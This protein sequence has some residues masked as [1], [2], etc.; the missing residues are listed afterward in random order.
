M[1]YRANQEFRRQVL[2]V[3]NDE[4][5]LAF[6]TQALELAGYEALGAFNR[7]QAE[8]ILAAERT[9][10]DVILVVDVVLQ[11]ESGLDLAGDF[12][13]L[14]PA[15]PILFISGYASDVLFLDGKAP[16]AHTGFL[17][18]PFSKD[19]LLEAVERLTR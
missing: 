2:V 11:G 3:E 13:R 4:I 9:A 10:A 19:D 14:H 12:A 1:G 7:P 6:L 15:S 5:M 17:R 18:K 8:Q 16:G